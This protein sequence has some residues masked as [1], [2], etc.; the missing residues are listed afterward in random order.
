MTDNET[1]AEN[2]ISPEARHAAARECV[3]D[4]TQ[5]RAHR[6]GYHVH[7]AINAENARLR[8]LVERAMF[9]MDAHELRE[10]TDEARD[11]LAPQEGE[12]HGHLSGRT[13]SQETA[14][15][16]PASLSALWN[17]DAPD[18][19]CWQCPDCASKASLGC[20]AGYHV[21]KTG[22]A[23]PSLV[24]LCTETAPTDGAPVAPTGQEPTLKTHCSDEPGVPTPFCPIEPPAD[25]G[26]TPLEVHVS[27]DTAK[28]LEE[29]PEFAQ[30]FN[31]M[32]KAVAASIAK[33]ATPEVDATPRN[34]PFHH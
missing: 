12:D 27:Q 23:L 19:L 7:L 31:G 29:N 16:L 2:T 4:A 21:K 11:A 3:N 10:W 22:H 24:P 13:E 18:G 5:P 9:G 8:K 28:S 32:M 15:V 25:P 20:N 26:G 14:T 1:T 34:G 17:T 30:A 33:E 6:L